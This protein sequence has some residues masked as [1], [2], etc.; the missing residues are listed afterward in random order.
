MYGDDDYKLCKAE[1]QMYIELIDMP[2]AVRISMLSMYTI[3]MYMYM[4]IYIYI[5]SIHIHVYIY[6]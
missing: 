5:Y 6:I 4:H 1:W 3:Y 2:E